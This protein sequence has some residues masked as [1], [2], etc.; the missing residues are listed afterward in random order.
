[1][2]ETVVVGA[3]A[4]GVAAARRLADA[5]V[6]VVLLEARRRP[7][8]RAWTVADPVGGPLDLGCGWLHSADENPWTGI[9]E[10]QARVV[11]RTPPAW[12]R[13]IP[14]INMP[15]D[16]AR[17]FEQENAA[18]HDR[19]AR[20]AQGDGPDLPASA[21]LGSES[22]WSGL[23]NA[24]STYVSGDELDRVS[25]RDLSAYHDSGINWRVPTGYGATVA[26]HA[27]GAP[28]RFD[29]LV[30]RID[31]SGLAIR[32]ETSQ[33]AIAAETAIVTVSSALIAAGAIAFTPALPDK[34]EAAHGLPL[35]LADKLF[36]GFHDGAAL[37]ADSRVFGRTDRAA[38]GAYHL[39]PFGRPVI[40]AYYGGPTALEL[41]RG[42]AEAF[43]AFAQEELRGLYGD[44]FA[45]TLRPLQ[46]HGWASDPFARGSYSSALPGRAGDR[47]ILA[48]P[49]DDRLFFAGEACSAGDY[50]T[51]HGAFRTG[52]AAADAILA[53]R[54][55]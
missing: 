41:E 44:D 2:V 38:T 52:V 28:I 51:A 11:D 48:A 24:I 23:L 6:D 46:H 42:G 27:R 40:E 4:A 7:G 13:P 15:P 14:A 22:R 19:I 3:G 53:R 25:I 8:G 43:F 1:M 20:A 31:H 55:R 17:A 10:G 16:E 37:D 39:R 54:T 9:A 35:G 50:S 12:V 26:E 49:V 36:L 45:K 21:L 18:F 30:R 32:I 29:C 47:A 5:G 34:V 33:G